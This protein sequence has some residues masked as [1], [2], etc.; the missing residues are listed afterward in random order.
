MSEKVMRAKVNVNECRVTKP[1]PGGMRY[2]DVVMSPV[3]GKF[4]DEG[5]SEDNTYSLWTPSGKIELVITNP[6]LIDKLN[7]GDQFYVDFIKVEEDVD[8]D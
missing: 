4:D 6:A 7:P 2:M 3:A 5:K 1:Y 8:T